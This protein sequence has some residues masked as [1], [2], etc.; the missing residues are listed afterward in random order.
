MA[1]EQWLA[2]NRNGLLPLYL[3][4]DPGQEVEQLAVGVIPERIAPVTAGEIVLAVA[5][6]EQIVTVA[7]EQSVLAISAVQGSDQ[8]QIGCID[9]ILPLIPDGNHFARRGG[10]EIA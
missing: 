10:R 2:I 9:Y 8:V 7:A 5:A 6:I 4:I 1:A 3:H